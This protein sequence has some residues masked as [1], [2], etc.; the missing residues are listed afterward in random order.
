M[1]DHDDQDLLPLEYDENGEVIP[2]TPPN[3]LDLSG[4][5][6]GGLNRTPSPPPGIPDGWDATERVNLQVDDWRFFYIHTASRE[7]SIREDHWVLQ[8]DQPRNGSEGLAAFILAQ[9]LHQNPRAIAP[10]VFA[11]QVGMFLVRGHSRRSC[12]FQ[13]L[14]DPDQYPALAAKLHAP[15]TTVQYDGTF[16]HLVWFV[17]SGGTQLQQFIITMPSDGSIQ[18]AEDWIYDVR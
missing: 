11:E 16:M 14:T 1:T 10:E 6:L 13:V 8:G 9:Q 2:S 17:R 15:E 5:I 3:T 18:K 4:R 12:S 7:M